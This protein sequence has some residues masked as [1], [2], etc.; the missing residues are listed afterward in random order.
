MHATVTNSQ[1]VQAPCVVYTSLYTDIYTYI[2]YVYLWLNDT[3][4]NTH[5]SSM[6]WLSR[7]DSRMY[8]W[9]DS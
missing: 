4:C 1:T 6:D 3:H 9:K 8:C 5:G 2:R 7:K